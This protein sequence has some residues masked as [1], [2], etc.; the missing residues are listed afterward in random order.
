[1]CMQWPGPLGWLTG[2]IFHNSA[3]FFS[4]E[5]FTMEQLRQNLAALTQKVASVV[6]RL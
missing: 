3:K 6:E 4:G 5:T 1:M 2:W